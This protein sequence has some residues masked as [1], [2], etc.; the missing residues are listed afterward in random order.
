MERYWTPE[1]VIQGLKEAMSS[2]K[3]P[4]PCSDNAYN[5]I[6]KGRFDWPSTIRIYEYHHS[7]ARAWLAAGAPRSRVSLKNIKWSPQEDAYLLDKAG[8]EKLGTIAKKLCRSYGSVKFR[9]NKNHHVS[10]RENQGFLS[11]AGIS[12][13]YN[14]PC[15]RV[16]NA[17]K[18]GLI[19]GTF[20]PVRNM[21]KVDLADIRVEAEEILKAPK[22]THKKYT[23][24]LGDY[25]RRHN[26]KRIMID[27]K[28]K[29]IEAWGVE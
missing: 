21:W 14:C 16:R 3:G 6:K 13:I 24:D 25:Y 22:R 28:L 10:A 19:N 7:M 9:L 29:R 8:I 5:K 18:N 27:G 1:R 23:T 20:D 4:L 26:L 17:L 12:K 11:A 15:H 2:I